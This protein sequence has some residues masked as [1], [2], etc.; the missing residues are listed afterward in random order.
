MVYAHTKI[1]LGDF[2]MQID[3][4]IPART[5]DQGKNN[6]AKKKK[7]RICQIVDFTISVDP[8]LKVKENQRKD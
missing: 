5:Q 1:C 7:N 3:Y 6:K 2:E 4:V 8:S